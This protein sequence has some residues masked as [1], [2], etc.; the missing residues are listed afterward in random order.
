M[1]LVSWIAVGSTIL[2]LLT[3]LATLFVLRNQRFHN[4]VLR[5]AQEKASESLGSRVELRDFDLHWRGAGPTLELQ[6]IV[7]HGGAPYADPPLLRAKSIYLQVTITSFLHR[8]WYLNDIRIDDPVARIFADKNG[9]TNI[10]TPPAQEPTQRKTNIF[11]LGI[12]HLALNRGEVYYNDQKAELSADVHDVSVQSS[13]DL[14]QKKYFG[15]IS[16]RDGHLQLQNAPQ[17]AHQLDL[18]FWAT[19]TTLTVEDA[20]LKT[21]LSYATFQARVDNY[22]QPKIHA[23]Y[24]AEVEGGELQR[25][26]KMESLPR[27]V[28]HVAGTMDYQDEPGLPFLATTNTNGTVRSDE[29]TFTHEKSVVKITRIGAEY[30]LQKGNALVNNMRAQLLGGS[31]DGALVIHDVSGNPRSNLTAELKQISTSAIQELASPATSN[32]AALRGTLNAKAGASWGK[33]FHDLVASASIGVEAGLAS[34]GRTTPVNA[35]IRGQYD[36][37]RELLSLQPSTVRTPQNTVSLA[38][39]VS[40]Q[41]SLQVRLQS[42]ELHEIEELA[43]AFMGPDRKPLGLYGQAEIASTVSGPPQNP[44]IRGQLNGNNLRLRD[45]AWKSAQVQFAAN[46]SSVRL[47]RGELIPAKQGRIAFQASTS[48]RKWSFTESS[49]FEVRLT[50]Q[51]I[52]APDVV[53][54]AGIQTPLTGTLNADLQAHGTQLAPIGQGKVVLS[55]AS[56]ADVALRSANLSF[57]GNGTSVSAKLQADLPAGAISGNLQYQPRQQ[58]YQADLHASQIKMDQLVPSRTR[59][60]EL[61]GLLNVNATGRGTLDN[62]GLQAAIEVPQLSIR[63]Q[64]IQNLKLTANV[65]N[66]VA[67]IDLGSEMVG[68]KTTG[69]GVIQLTGDY[70]ADVKFD[71]Q[72][73]PLQPLFAIY[74]PAQASALAGQTEL[75]ATLRGP[76]KQKTQLEAHVV[77]PQFS[78]KYKDAIQLAAAAPIRADYVNGTVDVKRSVIKGTG[79]D[80]TFQ[81]NIPAAASAPASM[82]LQGTVDLQLAQL[83]DPDITSGGQLKFDVDSYGRRSDPNLQGKIR[84]INASFAEAGAPLGLRDGN[85]VLTL[86]RNRLDISEFQGKVGG[87]TVTG[88]GGV[89]YRPDLQFD[90]AMKAQGIRLLYEQSV[91][92]TFNSDLALTGHYDDALL[93]GQVDVDQLSFTSNFDLLDF[94]GQFGGGDATLPPTGGLAEKLRLEVGIN[95]PGVL[96]LSSRNLSLAGSAALRLRGNAAQPVMLG[97]INLTDGDLIFYGNRYLIQGGTIDLRNPSRTEPVL[98]VAANTTINQYNIQMHFWGPADHL[99]TNYSSDPALPPS[100]IINLIAFG[101][102]AEA[103]AANPTP[104]GSLGA[105]SLIASQV[106]S[107]VTSRLAKVAGISQLSIDPVLGSSQQSPG[108]RI[109]IQQRVTSKVFVT[110]ATDL[111]STQQQAVKLEYQWNRR[112]S[113]NAVRNQNGGLSFETAFRKEW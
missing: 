100:D 34:N 107:Q 1:R 103:A 113:F 49:P 80:L 92:A 93:R 99:H 61:A 12:R 47:D 76:L 39:A 36:A 35:A 5:T 58:S 52:N 110:F 101:K 79:T 50:A 96:S 53:K 55:H 88:R 84:I 29:L 65:A 111:T 81:A 91:R 60:L 30:S 41:S 16:Y 66:H 9:K 95:T 62:P 11:D 98:D 2:L 73:I 46:S 69:H 27:G 54:A 43:S 14:L 17:L 109:A 33:T 89:V 32:R 24:R 82:L 94:A 106:S 48:L 67:T 3:V 23:T 15:S 6:D 13:Y 83:I 59:D 51:N 42:Q 18:R 40:R 86:T 75:H 70:P 45:T 7:V 63:K 56:V 57:Q 87:G 97:R 25:P 31:F 90:L 64:T 19:P 74:A 28:V 20:V 22:A 108:A 38:G 68:T 77:I 105:Q 37:R 72:A 8:N 104:P 78:L 85:G 10:P 4:Y 44:Q 26:L 71:T 102:T 112:T 21:R